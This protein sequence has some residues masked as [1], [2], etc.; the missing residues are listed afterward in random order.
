[1]RRDNVSP[2][3]ILTYGTAC[4]MFAD[5]LIANGRPTDLDTITAR[6]VEGWELDLREHVN[7]GDRPQPPS[8]L[9]AVL[10]LVRRAAGRRRDDGATRWG[11]DEAA[12]HGALRPARGG[13][14]CHQPHRLPGRIRRGSDGRTLGVSQEGRHVPLRP[15]KPGVQCWLARAV[16]G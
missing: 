1:M 7:V 3:T 14:G 8:R 16:D 9:A 6:D 10:L 12:P 13:S 11:K 4:R 15:R 5:W 2:N